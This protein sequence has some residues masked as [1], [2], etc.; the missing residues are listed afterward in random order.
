MAAE[1]R[2]E[3]GHPPPPARRILFQGLLQDE[4]DK[5]AAEITEVVEHY[6]T[7][8]NI[9]G[10]QSQFLLQSGQHIA[11]AGVPDPGADVGRRQASLG[12]DML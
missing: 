4:I 2:P 9:A 10:R 12:Q 7:P 11:P 8:S 5:R 6:A 3:G 1:A